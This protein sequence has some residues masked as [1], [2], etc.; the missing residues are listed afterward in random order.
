LDSTPRY[1]NQAESLIPFASRSLHVGL[2][3]LG[4]NLAGKSQRQRQ[5]MIMKERE[6]ISFI[7]DTQSS[8]G[9]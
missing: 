5:N 2:G 6:R 7:A 1:A 3:T 8:K 9:I 4:G